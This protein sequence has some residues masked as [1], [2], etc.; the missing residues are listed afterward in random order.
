MPIRDTATGYGWGSIL[1]HWATAIIIVVMLYVGSSI[2]SLLGAERQSTLVLHTSIAITTYALL[3]L[4]IV[5]RFAYG[6][7]G[8]LAKQR[9]LFFFIGKWVHIFMLVALAVMLISG[10]FLVWTMGEPIRVFDWFAIPSPLE[11]SL[12]LNAA[13]HAVHSWAAMFIFVA[14]L[15]HIGGVYK[16]TAFNQDG[17]LTKMIIAAREGQTALRDT[18]VPAK[19]DR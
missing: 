9:S 12:E 2:D 16:H 13:V 4:R 19:L 5:W 14:I 15:L 11:A 1:L 17:T 6:H 10:P 8:P 7:P 3:L 18:D